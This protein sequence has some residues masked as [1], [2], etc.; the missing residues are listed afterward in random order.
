MILYAQNTKKAY[1]KHFP[2]M[3]DGPVPHQILFW[4]SQVGQQ[5]ISLPGP[6]AHT[7][8]QYSNECDLCSLLCQLVSSV[9]GEINFE[10]IQPQLGQNKMVWMARCDGM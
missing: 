6:A 1:N 4:N 10:L 8:V 9:G 3:R 5:C 7:A 2:Q